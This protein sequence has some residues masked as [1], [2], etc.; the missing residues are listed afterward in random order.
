MLNQRLIMLTGIW[1]HVPCQNTR[2]EKSNL[3]GL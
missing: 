2:P 1:L 3:I